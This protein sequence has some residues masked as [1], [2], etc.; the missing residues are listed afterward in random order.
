MPILEK[1]LKNFNAKQRDIIISSVAY[2]LIALVFACAFLAFLIN[3]I[4][5]SGREFYIPLR[6][7]GGEVL[8]RDIFNIYGALSYQI[9][10]LAYM[11]L[12]VHLRSLAIFGT[13]NFALMAIVINL[14]V[15][16]FLKVDETKEKQ[17]CKNA[18]L[19]GI[20]F[21]FICFGFMNFS[22]FNYVVPYAFAM[23]YGLSAFLISLLF[24][25]KFTKND[26]LLYSSLACVFAGGAVACKY[27]FLAY[28]IFVIAYIL[29]RKNNVKN[30]IVN[31]VSLL[32][33]PV[34]SYGILFMQG[35]S[36]SDLI[37]TS[38]I[39]KAMANT[40]ALKY[41][42][43]NFTGTY[44]SLKLF[45]YGLLKT[46]ML[47][48]LSA[49]VF[50]AFKFAKQ[51]KFLCLIVLIS[52]CFGFYFIGISGFALF[53]VLH[54]IIYLVFFKKI[55]EN[56]QLFVFMS[57]VLLLSLKTF[58]IVNIESYGIYTFP[59]ILASLLFFVSETSEN[60]ENLKNVIT[61]IS[62]FLIATV[63]ITNLNSLGNRSYIAVDKPKIN[64]F[65]L[66][67]ISG[68]LTNKHVAKVFQDAADYMDKN[69]E[70]SDRVV[71]LPESQFFNFV[72]KRSADNYYDS[73]T[74]MYFDAFGE[75][76]VIKHFE[77]TKPEYFILNNRNTGDY[78]KRFICE[79]YAQNFC[80][81]VYNNYDR[82]EKFESGGFNFKIY[83]R[84]DLK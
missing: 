24:L 4:I 20:P 83:K 63:F 64:N 3:P 62:C 42:Y 14:I 81:F 82:I 25:I 15:G 52:G 72:A 77:E 22:I 79:D 76:N 65:V 28:F 46:S 70:P 1:F 45:G 47:L 6:M 12:G 48:I 32:V 60:S 74:P 61:T 9:N 16:E 68:I 19:L 18:F 56:R 43:S 71:V 40:E 2:G 80:T 29:F 69:T 26:R 57:A 84:K 66:V 31:I 53:A 51:D 49:I 17:C 13:L 35:M 34:V 75:E 55:F 39:L 10:T 11:I 7:L 36:I 44:F 38:H 5:D 8:Y 54:F 27:E 58:F 78:G 30:I 37:N 21:L 59:F 67:R 41:L 50:F 33:I 23:T 73:L